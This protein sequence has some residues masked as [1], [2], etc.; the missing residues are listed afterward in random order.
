MRAPADVVITPALLFVAAFF[1]FFWADFASRAAQLLRA[2]FDDR[3]SAFPP[4]PFDDPESGWLPILRELGL[5]SRVDRDAFLAAA[6]H[7]EAS[8]HAWAAGREGAAAAAEG[9]A[10]GGCLPPAL[11]AKASRLLR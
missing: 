11:E 4:P 3:P 8:G 2:V 1:L 6:R 5:K 10:G 9:P 7:V